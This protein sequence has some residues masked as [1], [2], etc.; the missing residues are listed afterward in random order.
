MQAFEKFVYEEKITVKFQIKPFTNKIDPIIFGD[1]TRPV[2]YL[3][4]MY[5]EDCYDAVLL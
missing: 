2:V 3:N 5:S 1:M 4:L